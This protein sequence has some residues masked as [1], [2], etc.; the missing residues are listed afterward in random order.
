MPVID[1]VVNY[2][3]ITKVLCVNK[4]KPILKCNGKCHLMKELAKASESEKPVPDKKN[5][6]LEQYEILFI[7]AIFEFESVKRIYKQ[8]HPFDNYMNLYQLLDKR[9]ILKPPIFR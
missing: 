8:I 7:Q 2:D 4:D 9:F 1:Y 3:Y 6:F 5:V